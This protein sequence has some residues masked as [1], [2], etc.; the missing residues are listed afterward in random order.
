MLCTILLPCR[1]SSQ[2][3]IPIFLCYEYFEKKKIYSVLI[4]WVSEENHF[5][6]YD[7]YLVK[8]LS[9]RKIQ[10]DSKI[11]GRIINL[12]V[13]SFEL[14]KLYDHLYLCPGPKFPAYNIE[15]PYILNFLV[16]P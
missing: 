15:I 1:N 10:I 7:R 11:F 8:S 4:F 16:H 6:Q 13:P 3:E 5:G 2:L 12:N 14:F 9:G